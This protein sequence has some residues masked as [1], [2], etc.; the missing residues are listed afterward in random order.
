MAAA[1]PLQTDLDSLTAT[2]RD[3]IENLLRNMPNDQREEVNDFY[4][5][6]KSKFGNDEKDTREE[7]KKIF[8]A[9]ISAFKI[10]EDMKTKTGNPSGTAPPPP[11]EPT[12]SDGNAI[13][14]PLKEVYDN[15]NPTT[16]AFLTEEF[17]K[18][19]TETTDNI[20][21]AFV[22]YSNNSPKAPPY[23]TDE[24]DKQLFNLMQSIQDKTENQNENLNTSNRPLSTTKGYV[25]PQNV[26][27]VLWSASEDKRKNFL[28][29][30]DTMNQ[31]D[32]LFIGVFYPIFQYSQK[33]K[34]PTKSEDEN[35]LEALSETLAATE[36]LKKDYNNI[37]NNINNTTGNTQQPSIVSQFFNQQPP[38]NQS[39]P[40]GNQ[41]SPPGNQSSPPGKQS[42]P[43]GNQQPPAVNPLAQNM[44]T[45]DEL[46]PILKTFWDDVKGW[47]S[48]YLKEISVGVGG[49]QYDSPF[50]ELHAQISVSP[51][52]SSNIKNPNTPFVVK[53]G[54]T[55]NNNHHVFL[56]LLNWNTQDAQL[57]VFVYETDTESFDEKKTNN[58]K[59]VMKNYVTDN[60]SADLTLTMYDEP[61]GDILLD[62]II[63]VAREMKIDEL[64]VQDIRLFGK[65]Y[66]YDANTNQKTNTVEDVLL[67]KYPL[68]TPVAGQNFFSRLP[69]HFDKPTEAKT[70]QTFLALVGNAKV[71]TGDVVKDVIP[72][73][74]QSRNLSGIQRHYLSIIIQQIQ[75]NSSI[76]DKDAFMRFT[77]DTT[78]NAKC[79][80]NAGNN[81]PTKGGG[82][83]RPASARSVRRGRGRSSTARQN[84][85]HGTTDANPTSQ[86]RTR[87]RRRGQRRATATA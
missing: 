27:D 44:P 76:T 26:A 54:S 10:V 77:I 34:T 48:G 23:V 58:V 16:K 42:S 2:Q 37:N 33:L 36:N 56:Q 41:S 18:F 4:V 28:V 17:R 83:G 74:M 81:G 82:R 31:E 46:A 61:L 85:S 40:P 50:R 69:G 32:L 6:Q 13:P 62:F 75:N 19:N 39:S 79:Y 80:E 87:K 47:F 45:Q 25:I 68:L 22:A 52:Y 7:N 11:E 9:M 53:L 51:K 1:A 70:V 59:I 63:C 73:F 72:N 15:G 71:Q 21:K 38:G 55:A 3:D 67:E 86:P 14:P 24:T 29:S 66:E 65:D 57:T 49:Q 64:K 8:D 78:L 20:K 12:D 84:R 30:L 5:V 60:E 35:A 43:P